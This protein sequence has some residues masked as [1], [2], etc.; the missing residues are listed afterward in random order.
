MPTYPVIIHGC[1]LALQVDDHLHNQNQAL[2]L[3]IEGGL[4]RSSSLFPYFMLVAIEAGSFLRGLILLCLYPF[5]C[6]FT[7]EVQLRVMVMVCFL[8]LREE[9]VARVARAT[10]P[11]HFLEDIGRE[12]LEIVGGFK[13]V[14]GLSRMI[15]R[16]MVED[17]LKVY[18][19]LEMV[20]GREVKMVRGRYVGLLEM[21]SERKLGLEKL[22]ETEMVGFGS[23]T[24]YFSHDYHQLFNCCKVRCTNM[25]SPAMFCLL[26]QYN[27]M[28][29]I[30]IWAIKHTASMPFSSLLPPF[31]FFHVMGFIAIFES[32]KFSLTV[33]LLLSI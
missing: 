27:E 17:F 10:L 7:Q 2:V 28:I 14:V 16:V 1:P 3:D 21:E 11:K 20:V 9:K 6:F 29:L 25:V 12:G 13:R 18:M 5:M 26:H 24:G 32:D 33:M 8:G 22:E 15:P 30:Y 4:L 23:C 31:L 19:G